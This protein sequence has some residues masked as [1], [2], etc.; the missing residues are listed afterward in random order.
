MDFE[1]NFFLLL[2]NSLEKQF[3]KFL[4]LSFSIHDK[5]IIQV[6]FKKERVVN[7]I[8]QSKSFISKNIFRK[9]NYSNNFAFLL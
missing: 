6:E 9:S 5:G 3:I 7:F 2:D 8:N 1:I 4:S